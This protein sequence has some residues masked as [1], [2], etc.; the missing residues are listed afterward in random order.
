M[1][2]I[3][4]ETIKNNLIVKYFMS[5][6]CPIAILLYNLICVKAKSVVIAIISTGRK[7]RV[8]LAN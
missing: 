6:M 5:E 4:T 3:L 1:C 7:K 8:K 2:D